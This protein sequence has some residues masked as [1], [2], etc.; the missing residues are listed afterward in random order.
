M[1]ESDSPSAIGMRIEYAEAPLALG[2]RRPRFSWEVALPGR[3]RRQSAYQV[4]VATEAGRLEPGKADL[5]DSG[6][7]ESSQSVNV[8]YAGA[9]L[10]SDMDACWRVRAWDEAGTAGGWSAVAAFGTGLL[11]EGDWEAEWIGLGKPDEPVADTATFQQG[12][13]APEVA[14]LEP[15]P[16]SPMLRRT[17]DIGKTVR[18]ARAY[19][20]GLGLFELRLNGRK[21]GEDVLSPSRTDFRK[22]VLVEAY[23]ILPLLASGENVVGV[24]LGNGW[25]N[26]QKKY[27]G[28]QMQWH[29]SPR[30]L[31]QLDIETADGTRQRVCSDAA[32]RGAW[33]PIT[34]NCL[35]DGEDYDARLEQEGWDAPGFDDSAWSAVNL[36]PGPG[37]RREMAAHEPGRVVER[38]RPVS[39]SEPEPGVFVYDL[40]RN[41]T[42]WVR[43]AVPNGRRGETIR[44]RF[45][46][47]VDERGRLDPRSNGAAR[48]EDRYTMKGGAAETYEPRFTYHGFQY[49]A[50]SGFPGTPGLEAITGC[51]V[52]TAVAE[53]GAFA[54]GHDGVNT[55]HRCTLQSQRCNIQ[56]GVPTDDTQR[57]ERLGWAGDAWSYANEAYY[58]FWMPRVFAKWIADFYDQQDDLGFVGMIAPQAGPEEDLVWSAAFV[59]IPWWQYLHCGDRRLLEE[60]YPYLQK[61]LAYLEATGR[62]T[63]RTMRTEEILEQ[64][65]WHCSREKRFPSAGE[66]GHLQISQWG[67]HLATNE[68]ASGARQNQPLS[69]ATAFYY[70]DVCTMARIAGVLGKADDARRYGELAEAIKAAFNERFFDPASGFF[71]VGCQSAQA[72]A[73]AFG[74]APDEHRERVQAFLNS[75]VNH[76]QQRLTTGYAGTKWAIA[77]IAESGRSDIVWSRVNDT[78]YPSWGYM[79]RDPKRTT[80]TENWMGSG[81]LC[82]TT[83]GAAID[84]WFYWGLAGIRPDA[85]GPGYERIVFKP[86]LPEDLA[87][88]WASVRTVRGRVS[89]RWRRDGRSVTLTVEVPANCGATVSLPVA[90]PEGVT[91][92]DVPLAEAEGVALK[93]TAEGATVVDIGSG[94]YVFRFEAPAEKP[95]R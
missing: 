71:D 90:G 23:D 35:Y 62:K 76:R 64:L 54:C 1:R 22:R 16:R 39:V 38:L 46:E 60:S 31:V 73:L 32:W 95:G 50:V 24:L 4:L 44:L 82:H 48:Q 3:G 2:T 67:D 58:N 94:E 12:R 28:W 77:A 68:G 6:R 53:T 66:H 14:A 10:G 83:L 18:R 17:F 63:V 11:D 21:V 79:L 88:A 92:G 34:S 65:F 13:V 87:W 84:E 85:T 15:D 33:S 19:V 69:I 42:G 52:R 51:F 27:W 89:S 43:L 78:H 30:A 74:L 86:Y 70:L 59:L 47:A 7:V 72:W 49:V 91:E 29:G 55:I 81:S 20:C 25:F 56:M 5:W 75:S 36:A 93:G 9:P 57:P 80:I 40:G 8:D 61:Y 37:G 45:A 41:M 26:G